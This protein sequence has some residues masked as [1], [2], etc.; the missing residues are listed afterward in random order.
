[1]PD[2]P[3]HYDRRFLITHFLRYEAAARELE[4]SE[5]DTVLEVG[6]GSRGVAPWISAGWR[7]TNCD[8]TFDDYGAAAPAAE[9]RASRV[10]GSVLDLPFES[11]AFDVVLALDLLEHLPGPERT[12][13][14]GEIARVARHTAIVGCPCGDIALRTDRGLAA[15]LKRRNHPIPPWLDEHLENGFPTGEELRAGLAPAGDV[16]LIRNTNVIARLAVSAAETSPRLNGYLRR[17]FARVAPAVRRR[18]V[19]RV[20]A[21]VIARVI[22]GFDLPPAYRQLAV[23][24]KRTPPAPPAS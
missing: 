8:L 11:G 12:R 20:R 13:A 15:I 4:R 23:L 7:I 5:G 17:V 3:A 16:R 18:G 1:V 21:S 10:T 19:A 22:R 2:V 6:G 14:L 24:A 9:G